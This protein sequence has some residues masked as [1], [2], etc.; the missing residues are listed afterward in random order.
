MI[1]LRRA[2]ERHHIERIK[3][4]RWLTFYALDRADPL[5][6][7]F[8]TLEVLTE[9]RLAPGAEGAFSPNHD[10][11]IITYVIEGTLAHEDSTGRSGVILAGEFQRWTAGPGVR[12]RETNALRT[13]PVHAFHIWLRP[14]QANREQS[15]EQKRFSAAERR[16]VLRVVA[17]QDGRNGSLRVCQDARLYSSM[18]DPGQHVVHELTE[19]R[20]GWLHVVRGEVTLG[21]LVL[22]S[23]DGAGIAEERAMSI[24]AREDSEVLLADMSESVSTPATRRT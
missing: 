8:G 18:L 21:D 23:G 15:E 11:E 12:R 24:T 22:T 10:T 1:T 13:D 9:S 6:R 20:R 16:G 7:G 4:D 17:S 14:S 3:H 5:S 2:A 19:G